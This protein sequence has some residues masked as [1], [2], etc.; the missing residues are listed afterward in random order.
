M[1]VGIKDRQKFTIVLSVIG[2]YIV[3]ISLATINLDSA[4]TA[5]VLIPL[6]LLHLYYYGIIHEF[7]HNVV[8]TTNKTNTYMGSWLYSLNV[9]SFHTS[10][11]V[12]F[13]QYR[14]AHTPVVDPVYTLNKQSIPYHT[15]WYVFVWPYLA[16][17][18]YIQH[19]SQ[20]HYCRHFLTIHFVHAAG[21]YSVFGIGYLL[22]ILPTTIFFWLLP[23]YLGTWFSIGIC[24]LIEHYSYYNVGCYR[25]SRTPTR[26]LLNKLTLNNFLSLEHHLRPSAAVSQLCG[27]HERNREICWEKRVFLVRSS[28]DQAHTSNAC[29]STR[30]L[31]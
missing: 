14:F 25:S 10:K 16:I 24:N 2:L 22:G 13:Q 29:R 15:T 11:T 21:L 31:A 26:P 5:W 1:H 6:S 23:V 12:H 18:W 4:Y 30:Q 8:F 7:V 28:A 17:W 20:S 3:T 27:L 19:I 9:P